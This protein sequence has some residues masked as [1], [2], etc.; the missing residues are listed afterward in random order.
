VK[1]LRTRPGFLPQLKLYVI[2]EYLMYIFTVLLQAWEYRLQH[3]YRSGQAKLGRV[4]LTKATD[5]GHG[6]PLYFLFVKVFAITFFLMSIFALPAL[7]FSFYGHGTLAQE[8]DAS[9]FYKLSIGNIGYNPASDNFLT[10]SNCTKSHSPD[11]QCLT[12]LSEEFTILQVSGILMVCEM[13]QVFLFLIAICSLSWAHSTIK[14]KLD[15]R[16]CSIIDYSV[17][18]ENIPIDTTVDELI[19]HFSTLYVLNQPDWKGRPAVDGAETVKHITN[20]NV[21]AHRGTWVAEA[22]IFKRIGA[23]IRSF[24][25]KQKLMDELLRCRA[26]MKM[27]ND[28]TCHANGPDPKRFL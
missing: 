5:I 8:Q 19:Q 20:T 3:V 10:K 24:K 15:D 21:A 11:M 14:H 18:V 26:K 6:L 2:I 27:Y 17:M 16:T 13:I 9:S 23:M 4:K 7:V 1:I 22:T 28:D 25:D 12:I